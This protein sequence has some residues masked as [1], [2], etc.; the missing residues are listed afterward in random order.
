MSE[1]KDTCPRGHDVDVALIATCGIVAAAIL[2]V[3]IVGLQAWFYHA[4]DAEHQ[5]KVVSQPYIELKSMQAKQLD[6]LHSYRFQD[7]DKGIVQ[8]PIDL[9]IERYLHQRTT[10]SA[11]QTD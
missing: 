2:V 6:Q 5:R 9:A 7:K 4:R 8:I 10:R 1:Q 11:T 3:L